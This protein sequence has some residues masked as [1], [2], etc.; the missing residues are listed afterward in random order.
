LIPSAAI[1]T[2][3][4]GTFIYVVGSDNKAQVRPVNVGITQ[5]TI[6]SIESGVSAGEL[7]VTD[8]QD[9]LQQGTLVDARQGGLGSAAP[10]PPAG[11]RSQAPGA[12]PPAPNAPPNSPNS[13][14]SKPSH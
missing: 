2:G 4:A 8:G 14:P 9:K 10:T 5:G 11:S 3:S 12:Q 1:Q 6:C 7:V 13:R